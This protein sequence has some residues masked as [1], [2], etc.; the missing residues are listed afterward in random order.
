LVTPCSSRSC[1]MALLA[2]GAVIST[3]ALGLSNA[4]T[5]ASCSAVGCGWRQTS[6]GVD[7][8]SLGGNRLRSR[9]HLEPPRVGRACTTLYNSSPDRGVKT[10]AYAGALHGPEAPSPRVKRARGGHR[11]NPNAPVLWRPRRFQRPAP[12]PPPAFP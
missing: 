8:A 4:I 1:S 5:Q 9:R 3:S 2:G 11:H 7:T 10:S 12:P 6:H